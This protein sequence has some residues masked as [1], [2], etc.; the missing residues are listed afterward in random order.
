[1]QDRYTNEAMEQMLTPFELTRERISDILTDAFEGG[2]NSWYWIDSFIEPTSWDFTS[3]SP[4]SPGRHWRQD[5]PL[6]YCG[7]LIMSSTLEPDLAPIRLDIESVV[8]GLAVLKEKYP[9]HF[10]D[11]VEEHDDAITADA[12]LQCA[13][14]GE[15]VYG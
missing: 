13:L 8:R 7:A 5:Y 11:I 12:F 2:S 10:D 14:F 9:H 1:M 15:I 4:P 3:D 6:N